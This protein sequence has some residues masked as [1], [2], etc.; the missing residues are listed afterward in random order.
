MT[1]PVFDSGGVTLYR[2]DCVEVMKGLPANSIDAICTDPPYG[3]SF[4]GKKWDDPG[5]NVAFQKWTERWAREAIRVLKPGGHLLS[6]SAARTY[7]RMACGVEDAGFEIRDTIG[8]VY[9]TG[10]PK[11]FDVSKKID[12]MKGAERQLVE[13]EQMLLEGGQDTETSTSGISTAIDLETGGWADGAGAVVVAKTLPASEEAQQWAGWGTALKPAIEPIAVARKPFAGGVAE[14]V[15]KHGTGALNVAG[16]GVPVDGETKWPANVALEH[17]R[18]CGL[19]CEPGCP[20][21]LFGL[22][23]EIDLDAIFFC[24]KPSRWEK[25]AGLGILGE[26]EKAGVHAGPGGFSGKSV[27]RKNIHPTVKPIGIMQWLVRMT[28]PPGGVVL[29]PFMGSGTTG[30]AAVQEDRVF[31]GIDLDEEGTYVE[32]A[33]QRIEHWA[34]AVQMDLFGG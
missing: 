21:E 9:A 22:R 29:D 2:G 24:V 3:I 6:F 8:W 18:G 34:G 11:N 10:Y 30:C 4:M 1:E 16:T 13:K 19:R 15:L 32:I 14:N 23:A 12:A 5:G 7:H 27:P 31:V 26:R 28:T 20:V 33:R 17:L 25:E